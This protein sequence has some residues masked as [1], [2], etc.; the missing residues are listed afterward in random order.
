MIEIYEQLPMPQSIHESRA[1]ILLVTVGLSQCNSSQKRGHVEIHHLWGDLDFGAFIL[2]DCIKI[3]LKSKS[4]HKV[5][6]K[7]DKTSK[8][9][10][11][12]SLEQV[13]L[14]LNS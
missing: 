4:S 3:I 5:Q 6:P 14:T 7:S 8:M 11:H 2:L 9:Q 1:W 13:H 10:L 12:L